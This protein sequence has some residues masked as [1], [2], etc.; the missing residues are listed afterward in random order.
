MNN[1]FKWLLSGLIFGIGG[2]CAVFFI[3]EI[4]RSNRQLGL[5]G[6][7]II[8]CFIVFSF[9]SLIKFTTDKWDIFV[10]I[11]IGIVPLLALLANGL[12]F[13]VWYLTK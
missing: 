10:S 4:I 3:E 8:F 5:L 2:F 9:F 13:T 1:N 7:T 6:L 11:I 12:I